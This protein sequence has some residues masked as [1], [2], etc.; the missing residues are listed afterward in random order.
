M[1]EYHRQKYSHIVFYRFFHNFYAATIMPENSLDKLFSNPVSRRIWESKYR[2][3]AESSIEESWQRISRAIASREE[4]DKNLW[5]QKYY[6]V[7]TDFRFLPGGRIQAGAGTDRNVTLF[8][9]F[10]MG[11]IEDSMNGIFD[12]LKEGALT[13]QQGGGA[14]YDFSTLR[15]RGFQAK[16]SGTIA[17]G[18][19]SFMHIWDSMCATLIS[20][21]NRRG[22]MMATLRCDHPDIEQFIE[23]KHSRDALQH[24]NLS[25]LV[26]DRFM[27][28]VENDEMWPLTFPESG[29]VTRNIPAQQLW[30]K[31]M[32]SSYD[33]AEPGVLFIDQI[34]KQNNLYYCEHISATNPCGEVPLP[35]YGACDL[36]SLNLTQFIDNPFTGNAHFNMDG[37]RSAATVAV[38]MLDNIIDISHYPL[39][40]QQTMANNTRRIG[41]GITGLADCLIMLNLRYDSQAALDFAGN[42]ISELCCSA[43]L[44][45]IELA[46]ERGPFPLF[47]KEAYLQSAFIKKLP[48]DIKDGI[49]R[50]GIRNS[51]LLAIAPAGT[52]SLLANN[53]SS[54]L[55]PVFSL[56]HSR[57][58]FFSDSE[59][60][61]V[62]LEDYAHYLW[63]QL[64]ADKP[65]NNNFVTTRDLKP[66]AHLNM[67]A[68]IQPW[69][70]NAVSKTINIPAD[71]PFQDYSH[72]Y[73]QAWK[74]GLKG[75]TGFRPNAV[76]GQILRAEKTACCDPFSGHGDSSD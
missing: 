11:Q 58:L 45:S 62:E 46:R 48:D 15:P 44:A 54:S 38:R 31:I 30:Q 53:I 40:Q 10:V 70:D 57:S 41:L 49:A 16:Q 69:V 8:N 7:L 47:D 68:A 24:F 50:H 42:I 71:L 14:G 65:V 33:T 4:Q 56:T 13:M 6:D 1:S 75:C 9:C 34:N 19:V 26:T 66:D 52:I 55:E 74:L 67:Q 18:P 25:V 61:L 43:Y 22:A 27:Q 12:A 76:R 72:I 39:P 5:Q 51:H 29:E 59:Q 35:A 36:G 37:F 2:Y 20:S 60:Q 3:E 28:A 64:Y 23:A 73:K 21:G 63:R 17:S 32:Q